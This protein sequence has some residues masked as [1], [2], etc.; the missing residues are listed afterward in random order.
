MPEN[1]IAII[2]MGC[3]FPGAKDPAS[4]WQLLRE[5]V[6]GVS[7]VPS[8]RWDVNSFYLEDPATPGKMNT[9]WG[10]FLEN[11]QEF[12]AN[13]FKISPREAER[14]DPQ[15]RLLLEVTWEA[16]E[17]AHIVPHSLSGSQT[18]VFVGISNSDYG[19]LLFKDLE[20]INAYN[21][22]GAAFCIAANRISYFLNLKGPSL[23]IDTACS[24][25]LVSL[26]Y[27]CQ[28]LLSGESDL[29]LA[30]GVNLILSPELNINFSQARMMAADGRCKTFDDG[31]DGY[32]RG[33]GCGV[34]VLKRFSDA[35]N[36]GDKIHAIIRGSAINQDGLT[37][38]ITAP[39]GPSQQAVIRQALQNA[40]VTPNQISY[41]EAHGTGTAL[42]DPQEFK[43]LKAILGKGRPLDHPCW[44]GSV[45]TNIGHL[46]S[47]A[48]IAGLIKVVLCLEH[49][50]IPPHLH[51][52]K[53]NRYISLKGAPLQ[54]PTECTP[55]EIAT[56]KR[57]AGISSFGFGGT[58]CH[59]ILEEAPV[60]SEK[61]DSGNPERLTHILTL[62]AKSES[63]LIAL[64]DSY[65]TF[66][67][68]RH[69]L[70]VADICFSANTR[71][72]QFEHRLA[73]VA[74]NVEQLQK[75]LG[76][77]TAG[78][79]TAEWLHGFV[80]KRQS[81]KI[82]FLFTGQ[83]SQYVGMGRQLYETQPTFRKNLDYC[84]KILD[85]YLPLPLISILYPQSESEAAK[86]QLNQTA[87]TQPAIFALEYALAQLWLS[88]GI[89]PDVVMGH[90]VG[91][92]VA[93]CLA[94][95]FSLDDGLKLIATRGKLMQQ[96][97]KGGKMLAL[98]ASEAQVQTLIAPYRDQV[99][100][101]AIN[102]SQNIVVS[103]D[104]TALDAMANLF[105][106]E[107]IKSKALDVSHAFHSY[108][109]EP[110]LAAFEAVANQVTYHS[111]QISLISNVTG[112]PADE[113]IATPQ[114]WVRH[115]RQPVRFAEGMETL[116]SQGY[117]LYLEIGPKPILLG[118]GSQC[119]PANENGWLPSLHPRQDDWQQI[120]QTLANLYVRGVQVNWTE[121]HQ[122]DN[123]QLL[124]LPTYPFQRQRYWIDIQPTSHK[125]LEPDYS[126]TSSNSYL[127]PKPT[128]Q[129]LS[130]GMVVQELPSN[131]Q[132]LQTYLNFQV[133]RVLGLSAS[134]IEQHKLLGELGLDSLMAVELKNKITKDF[135]SNS[136][137][138]SNKDAIANQL[139]I[140]FLD[141]SIEQLTTQL[142]EVLTNDS[143]SLNLDSDA[144]SFS[145]SLIEI[146]S[147]TSK[148]PFVYV[149]PGV[150]MNFYESLASHLGSDQP[151]Y[152]LKLSGLETFSDKNH[153][154]RHPIE[155][156]A[157]IC[158]SE[159][160]K[161]SSSIPYQLGGWSFGGVVALEI[162]QQLHQ[163]NHPVALLTLLDVGNLPTEDNA[164]FLSWFASYLGSRHGVEIPFDSQKNR[165]LDWREQLNQLL[166]VTIEQRI[167]PQN[168]QTSDLQQFFETYKRELQKSIQIARSYPVPAY[169]HRTVLFQAQKSLM[170]NKRNNEFLS[171]AANLSSLNQQQTIAIQII[172]GDHYSI[173]IEPN[174]SALSRE[175][176]RYLQSIN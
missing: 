24:S 96:L 148:S 87:F 169:P 3:R 5:G 121:F 52:K 34:V 4:Y 152:V 63:A 30:G 111:P 153:N 101:A 124:E 115:V 42:G 140:Q 8:E 6:D 79:E 64:A 80:S 158:L 38:G 106:S 94:G 125:T 1:A 72:S 97:P 86:S 118:M 40:G 142:F 26:H 147:G 55:W 88:W 11:I 171:L 84:A 66:L 131:P 74:N 175:L 92:Y 2:G 166:A 7:E 163:Q 135:I 130:P 58:N 90:S 23:A 138:Y 57:F 70:P 110:M 22:T 36:D 120:L 165:K 14:L 170:E 21:G 102:G 54:I 12:D 144:F 17:N 65:Q 62:S 76:D 67:N 59:V 69:R 104:A 150:E 119:L 28:S 149:H 157:S 81:P 51:L 161:L 50:E 35:F 154:N 146:Q 29:C 126:Q 98:M 133:A 83:G 49:Q 61:T 108:L 107:G 155:Q 117:Q 46:G 48:G 160:E 136:P 44:I 103:G 16:L 37:S 93:A 141:L 127:E 100:F 20:G 91:E 27:A 60:L 164:T 173:F 10:G 78:N 25:S 132:A 32:V 159:L 167:L 116:H 156:I 168:T 134:E 122:F 33:E 151:F 41:V 128:P 56:D 172:P 143:D 53:L 129:S 82:A 9:R 71:R 31:A 13:F 43:S 109:M 19:R 114:Y 162:A 123:Q 176:K 15:Q 89:K 174:I 139:T 137:K 39:N 113:N 75:C 95:V 77:F 47:A 73:V 45:K 112:Q 145:C 85:A 105:E 99:S 68:S 18:G